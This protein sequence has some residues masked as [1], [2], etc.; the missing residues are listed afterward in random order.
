MRVQRLWGFKK[1]I[2]FL[3]FAACSAGGNGR[4]VT[5]VPYGRKK[6][7]ETRRRE[8]TP[9]KGQEEG[10]ERDGVRGAFLRDVALAGHHAYVTLREGHVRAYNTIRGVIPPSPLS[11]TPL[12]LQLHRRHRPRCRELCSS[13][14]F[15]R[16]LS[17]S[18]PY[19]LRGRVYI[20]SSN[21]MY[22][23]VRDLFCEIYKALLFKNLEK[24]FPSSCIFRVV[25]SSIFLIRKSDKILRK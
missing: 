13:F 20:F 2:F 1:K 6:D 25:S 23:R 17:I 15:V 12:Q 7:K 3:R 9:R 24:Y 14:L 18:D 4:A 11:R 21:V 19:I 10:R 16:C 5:S 8:H 22:T